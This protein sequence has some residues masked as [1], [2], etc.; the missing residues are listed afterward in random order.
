M[1]EQHEIDPA[2]GPRLQ[3][4]AGYGNP[5]WVRTDPLRGPV[6]WAQVNSR[7]W[8]IDARVYLVKYER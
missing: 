7:V 2:V 4:S 5:D 1:H 8:G 6:L 3:D